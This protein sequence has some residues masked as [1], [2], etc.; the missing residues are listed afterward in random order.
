MRLQR[1]IRK[2]IECVGIGLHGGRKVRLNLRP[3][4]ADTGIV[5]HRTDVADFHVRAGVDVVCDVDHAT[6]I[7][8]PDPDR[9]ERLGTVEHLLSALYGLGVDNIHVEADSDEVPILDGSAAPFVYLI[10][11]DRKS[12]GRER[13]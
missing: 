3:A 4:P 5:L 2:E 11:E 9:K 10:H 1:T 7:R 12:V 13:V 8:H 6:S